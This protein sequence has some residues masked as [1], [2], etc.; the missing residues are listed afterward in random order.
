MHNL[1]DDEIFKSIFS[2]ENVC[3]FEKKHVDYLCLE[4]NHK[5]NKQQRKNNCGFQTKHIKSM[6][7]LKQNS[8]S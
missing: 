4:K 2:F 7:M 3:D 1:H 5:A 8:K 6:H